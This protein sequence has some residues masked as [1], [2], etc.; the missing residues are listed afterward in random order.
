MAHPE[1]GNRPG[2]VCRHHWSNFQ[3]DGGWIKWLCSKCE[4]EW[5]S[6][7]EPGLRARISNLFPGLLP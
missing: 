6:V 5:L 4:L 1:D 3:R 7:P 2:D